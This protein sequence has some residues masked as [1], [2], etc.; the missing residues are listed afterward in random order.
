MS[1]MA[2]FC[3]VLFPARCLG[4]DL[5]LRLS[6]FLRLFLRILMYNDVRDRCMRDLFLVKEYQCDVRAKGKNDDFPQNL[7]VF[8]GSNRF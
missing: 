2:S 8:L 4:W 6:Q 1:L 7:T 3:A 5:G